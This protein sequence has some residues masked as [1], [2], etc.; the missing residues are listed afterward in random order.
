MTLSSLTNRVSYT[1]NGAVDTYAY[2]F[3]IFSNTDLLVT[4]RDTDDV[5]T[6]L[7]L[8]T[9]YTVTGVGGLTGGNVVL[10]NSA[11]AWLDGDGDLLSGFAL[12]IRRVR[13][14]K[15][16]TDIRNQGDYY[17]E[18]TEDQFDSLVMI[19]QQ[20]QDEIDRSLK[21]PE[22]VSSSD[23]DPTLPADIAG[24]IDCVPITNAAG[25]GWADA[26]DWPTATE[27]INAATNAT[28][29][30][31]SATLASEWA[32]KTDGQVAATDYSAKAWAIGGTDVTDTASR[33]A[34][35]EWAIETASTVDGTDYSA[36]EW[37]KGTQVRG[38]ASGGSAKDWAN[39]TG[40]TVDNSEYSAKKYATDAAVSAAAASSTLASALWR[41]VEFKTAS[42]SITSADNGKL[43]V[44]DTTSG[45]ITA[46][47]DQIATLTMPFNVGIKLD[48]GP[49]AVTLAR[50]SPDLFGNGATSRTLTVAGSGM[51]LVA[52][53]GTSPDEWTEIE[54][55]IQTGNMLVDV[56]SGTGAQTA[57]T[58]SVDPGSENNTWVFV[59]GVFIHKSAYSVSGTTLTFAVAPANA[60]NNIEVMIGTTLSIGTPADGT[61]STIKL[62]DLAVTTAKIDDLGVTTGKLAASAVTTS[63]ITDANVT[64]AKLASDAIDLAIVNGRLTL[65]TATP[66]P[67]TDQSGKTTV[68]FTPYKGNRLALYD[69]S[70]WA[71]KNFTEKSVAVPS[72][73]NTPFDIF[74]YDN[75]GTITLEAVAWT[76]DTTRATA[77]TTQDGVYV[78]TGSTTKR[79]LGT[80][81]TT[82]STGECE[83]SL[84]KRFLWNYYNRSPAGMKKTDAT[85]SWTYGTVSWRQ[86]NNSSTNQVAFVLGVLEDG[87]WA[88]ARG[89]GQQTAGDYS[90]GGG[91]GINSVSTNS[92]QIAGTLSNGS[93]AGD[94]RGKAGLVAGYNFVAWLEI[95]STGGSTIFYGEGQSGR[96]SCGLNAE[97][98]C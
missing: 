28:A 40:G 91:L 39:Y 44:C 22:T 23:F 65:A 76:N 78:K 55:G 54:F 85:T 60:S 57:F 25:D 31:A 19:D 33:G 53:T 50:T 13:P 81:R 7:T 16:E 64:A 51:Q 24:S 36:K 70:N 82:G 61:V 62:V 83:Y 48:A 6:T 10:V 96:H 3:R 63:K 47:F 14:L 67:S 80:G 49:N 71:L 93:F 35:K 43:F 92:A 34:A 29:A 32:S 42:F 68:Y 56:F 73:T 37:A 41:D 9:D 27:I 58:L 59:S 5:E 75:A 20:Q 66:M 17:P 4:V 1:G 98:L 74:V 97:I 21:L 18:G 94:F 89:A 52:D 15:Q 87:I 69:G 45:A 38:I 95:G 84:E 12:I 46:T 2:T 72:N 77:L 11:Q 88:S 30:D 79:Y 26:A 86:A 8:T 90:N